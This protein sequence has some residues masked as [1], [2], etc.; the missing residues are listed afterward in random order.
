[1]STT[2]MDN[3][4][5]LLRGSQLDLAQDPLTMRP[6]YRAMLTAAPVPA[7]VQTEPTALGRVPALRV[8]IEGTVP[9][10]TI[11][12]FHGG[13]Y[14]VGAPET[15]LTV[16]AN[17]ARRTGAEVVS[18]DYRLTPEHRYPA[19]VDDALT[20]Y[21]ALLDA[22]GDP[23]RI[24]VAGESAGAGLA[25]ATLL[26]AR[27][28]GLPQPAA[29]LLLSPWVDLTQS[30]RSLE[31]KAEVDPSMTATAL[32]VRAADYLGDA[33]PRGELASPALAD[34]RGLPPILV[35]A[36][37]HEVLLDDAVRLA[38]RAAEGDVDVTLDV[39]AG[40]PHVFQAFAAVLDEAAAALD[41]AA[42]FL[43]DRLHPAASP[44]QVVA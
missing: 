29:A 23:L 18:V 4:T 3:V 20:A 35:Q 15:S 17:L 22:G 24:A 21:R 34:L 41:R 30:G 39:V 33:D 14:A 13:C 11:V 8:R 7:D 37:S 26:A 10:A 1:M 36:G 43:R 5:A 9:T 42:A 40:A 16:V 28:A 19:A 12:H 31:S 32:R 38:A 25:M 6:V 2:Q 27:R 44:T